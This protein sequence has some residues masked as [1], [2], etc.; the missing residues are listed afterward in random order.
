MIEQQEKPTFLLNARGFQTPID[1]IK[2][3]DILKHDLVTALAKEAKALSKTHYD[4]KRKTFTEVN[5]LISLVAGEYDVNIG[6]AKGNV[7]LTSYD[8]KLRIQVGIA[9]QISFGAEIDIAKQLITEVIE[10]E[11]SDTNSFITQ[12]MRDAFEA[13]KQGHY[14]KN[15]ILALRKYRDAN[16]TEKWEAA[17]K[18]LDEAIICSDSKTYITFQERNIEGAWVQI[19]LVSKS[20]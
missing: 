2:P 13:D 15:R 7:S 11:L 12:L 10:D 1:D 4:F 3:Q 20:L 5:N 8:Q 6:G 9:D 14:N 18:A 19:P 17:M 16:K